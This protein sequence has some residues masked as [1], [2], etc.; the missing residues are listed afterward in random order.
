MEIIQSIESMQRRSCSLKRSGKRIGMVPTMGYFHE[1]HLSLMRLARSKADIVVVS[2]FVNPTQFAP[3]EDLDKYPRNFERDCHKAET[4]PVDIMFAPRNEDMY[5]EDFRTYVEVGEWGKKLC[6]LSRPA[7]FRGVTTIVLKLFNIVQPDI[8]VF[9]WKDAQQFL[10]L[11]RMVKDMNLPIEMIGGDIVR[12][13]DGLAMSS[14]NKYLTP[15]ERKDAVILSRSLK[16]A[17]EMIERGAM[18]ADVLKERIRKM[19]NGA[20]YGRLDY[21]E[22][23]SRET[24]EP[25]SRV[26]K[27]ESLIALAAYFGEARLIDNIRY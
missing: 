5:P 14:R 21:V 15:E 9:G 11:C 27:G 20:Q 7:H 25:L 24:L 26:Q 22:I 17:R 13:P 23:V 1:G 2:N 4:I 6:G 3:T 19:V 18:E 8:A 12:E 10:I 16:E